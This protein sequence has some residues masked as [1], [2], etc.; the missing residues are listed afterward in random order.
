MIS[1]DKGSVLVSCMGWVDHGDLWVLDMSSGVP[2]RLSIGSGAKYLQPHAGRDGYFAVGHHFDGPRFEVTVH[3]FTKPAFAV[4]R[5]T[6]TASGGELSGDASVW[7]HVPQLYVPYIALPG[8]KDFVL[9]RIDS[10]RG[11]VNVQALA[12]YDHRFDKGYQGVVSVTELPD[13]VALFSI[14]RSSELILHDLQTGAQRGAVDLGGGRG[15]PHLRLRT[16]APEIW[17][18][19]YD[20]L[21][22]VDPSTWR[23]IARPRLQDAAVGTQQFIGDFAFDADEKACAVAR[24]FSG[25]VVGLHPSNIKIEWRAG[26][27]RQPLEVAVVPDHEV[28]ARDWKTGEMLRGKLERSSSAT[29]RST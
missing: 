19:D 6:V 14:Q 22:K 21:V 24:P 25:D 10:A 16:R 1:D 2:T 23:V 18:G 12:W 5:A 15:N 13:E 11:S 29:P 27:G 17:A 3:A 4:A 28:I 26:L 7:E 20:T 8:L 9:F